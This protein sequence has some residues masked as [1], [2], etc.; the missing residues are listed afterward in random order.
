MARS[1]FNLPKGYSF[2]I[3]ESRRGHAV[4][5]QTFEKDMSKFAKSYMEFV[6]TADGWVRVKW[7]VPASQVLKGMEIT[8]EY[9]RQQMDMT[10]RTADRLVEEMRKWYGPAT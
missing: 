7:D 5:G 4:L 1:S 3:M 9:T 8:F 6:L 2:D 10:A